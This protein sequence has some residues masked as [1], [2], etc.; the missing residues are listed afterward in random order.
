MLHGKDIVEGEDYS[1]E[2]NY[3]TEKVTDMSKK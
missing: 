2:N 1:L 3:F